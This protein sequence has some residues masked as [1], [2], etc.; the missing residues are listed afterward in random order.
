MLGPLHPIE[1][2]MS[3]LQIK[4]PKCANRE[5]KVPRNNLR[6]TDKITCAKCGFTGTYAKVLGPQATKYAQDALEKAIK[7]PR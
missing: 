4:C 1:N 2:L 7:R 3:P 5:F 6:D